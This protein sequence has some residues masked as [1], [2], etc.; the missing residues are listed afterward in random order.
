MTL[1][2]IPAPKVRTR[3]RVSYAGYVQSTRPSDSRLPLVDRNLVNTDFT[4]YRN[5]GDTRAVLR[6]FI[7]SSPDLSSAVFAYLRTAIT[8]GYLAVA[9]N[10]D[11]SFNR[12]ATNLLLQLITRMDLLAD[13]SQGYNGSASLRSTSEAMGK[14]I[15][16]YG[17]CALE[18][19][20]DKS[21][22]PSKM[23]AVSTTR[24]QFKPE[25]KDLKPVQVVSGSEIDLDVP[26]FFY[27]ALDQDLLSAYSASPLEPAMKPVLFA[28]DFMND[29]RRIVKRVLHPRLKV[30][31][32]ES[33]VKENAP[34]EATSSAESFRDHLNKVKDTITS[35]I[36]GL[37]P[38]DALVFYDSVDVSLENNGNTRLSDEY[39]VLQS[40]LDSKMATGGKSMPSILGHGTQSANIA[41][42]ET[43]LFSKAA[44]GAVQEKLNE[45][46]SRAL[47]LAI[48][49][50]GLD[51][52]VEFKYKPIDLRPEAELEAFRQSKQS[53]VLEMLSLGLISDDE[54]ALDLTGHLPPDGYK[55]LSGTMFRSQAAQDVSGDGSSNDGS[56]LNKSLGTNAPTQGRGENNKRNPQKIK[57]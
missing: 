40:I 31:I 8:S 42:T 4:T 17:S 52:Y 14:E 23:V 37:A 9:K 57:E 38:E 28:E 55:P 13:Y 34:D 5:A 54:A 30:V 39:E 26:T 36:N 1:P 20:L 47:T 45:I 43:M 12:E 32:N 7:A 24:I 16:A 48:R 46:Y 51:C 49:L 50:Y 56:A 33:K 44:A 15:M 18:L 29:L 21:R 2:E 41:S 22:L 11:G 19:V 3:D 53:R 25:G 6:E 35:V 27:V 10:P